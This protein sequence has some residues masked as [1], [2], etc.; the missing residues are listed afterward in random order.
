MIEFGHFAR[1]SPSTYAVYILASRSRVIYIG[2]TNDL[3]RRLAEHRIGLGAEFPRKYRCHSLVYFEL[4]RSREEVLGWERKLKGW[5]RAKK[6]ALI[7][8][9]NPGWIDLSKD[10]DLPVVK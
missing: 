2:S 9:V 6:I 3:G 10:W 5:V 4:G 1:M 8:G 7:E